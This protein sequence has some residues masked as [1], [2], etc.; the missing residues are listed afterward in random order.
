MGTVFLAHDAYAAAAA[1][2]ALVKGGEL[3]AG[4]RRQ[5]LLQGHWVTSL[6]PF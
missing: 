5:R 6:L 4:L 2:A 3:H 1:A